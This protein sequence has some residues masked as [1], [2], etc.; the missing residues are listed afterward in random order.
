VSCL[1]CDIVAHKALASIIYED[2]KAMIFLDL[3]PIREGHALVIPKCHESHVERLDNDVASHLFLLARRL[4]RAQRLAGIRAD[5]HNL[6]INNGKAA[7]QHVPHVHLHVIPRL[8]G[9]TLSRAV[10]WGTRMLN[11]AGIEKRRRRLDA[12]AAM[13]A[14]AFADTN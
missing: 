14:K 13:L 7:N 4:V 1:F 3:F 10:V 2:D 6:L 12:Q 8:M 11:V 9:D 5:A